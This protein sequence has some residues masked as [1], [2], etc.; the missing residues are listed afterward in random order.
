MNPS[1]PRNQLIC[2]WFIMKLFKNIQNNSEFKQLLEPWR[3]SFYPSLQ[4]VS[5]TTQA[6]YSSLRSN[7][8]EQNTWYHNISH[9]G[10]GRPALVWRLCSGYDFFLSLLCHCTLQSFLQ[11]G[12]RGLPA[13]HRGRAPLFHNWCILQRSWREDQVSHQDSRNATNFI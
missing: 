13:Q 8:R 11:A 1:W 3:S 5:T 7:G 4:W 6:M 10:K 2:R 12:R 9:W